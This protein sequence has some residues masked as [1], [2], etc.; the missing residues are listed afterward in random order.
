VAAGAKSRELIPV[1]GATG[2]AQLVVGLLLAVG[3]AI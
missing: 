2:K 3:L 1:L